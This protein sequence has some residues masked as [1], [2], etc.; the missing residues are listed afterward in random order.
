MINCTL[1]CTWKG[2]EKANLIISKWTPSPQNVA[3]NLSNMRNAQHFNILRVTCSDRSA[4]LKHRHVTSPES[5]FL[6]CSIMTFQRLR[7]KSQSSSKALRIWH[8]SFRFHFHANSDEEVEGQTEQN[9]FLRSLSPS[10]CLYLC[11]VFDLVS[12]GGSQP[13]TPQWPSG[14]WGFIARSVCPALC[15]SAFVWQVF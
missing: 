2:Q 7:G 4:L 11:P 14:K 9:F 10:C 1:S 8:F 5:C 12:S 6:K 13:V 15:M 3:D